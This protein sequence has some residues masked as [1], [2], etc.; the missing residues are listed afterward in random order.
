MYHGDGAVELERFIASAKSRGEVALVVSTIGDAAAPLSHSPLS[1]WDASV[2]W[3]LFGS[4]LGG[5]R[6]PVGAH[7]S[8]ARGLDP[9]DRDLGLRLLNRP[10]HA[11]W[12]T[13]EMAIHDVYSG[14]GR[15]LPAE[16]PSGEL[17]PILISTLGEPVVAAWVDDD[18]R[19]YVLPDS[20][21]W[22]AVLDWLVRQA[23]PTYLPGALR[24]G[25]HAAFV[26]PDLQT[27]AE[28]RARAGL[29]ELEDEYAE[30]RA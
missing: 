2:R 5:P 9:A 20:T 14:G 12:W 29:A 21:D 15:R 30:R 17:H 8:L 19:W 4:A 26:D 7:P 1:R 3:P 10:A 16:T 27:A 28:T 18:V 25:R 11:A 6:L 23:L 22:D 13:L 24:R